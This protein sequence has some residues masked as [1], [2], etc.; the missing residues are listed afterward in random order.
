MTGVGLLPASGAP[1]FK[2]F[3]RTP[4]QRLFER[5]NFPEVLMHDDP[6]VA[7]AIADWIDANMMTVLP[8]SPVGPDDEDNDGNYVGISVQ[9]TCDLN[10]LE[11]ED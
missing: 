11:N 5:L 8:E 4:A 3:M 7:F 10:N 9:E 1:S 2:K 6:R